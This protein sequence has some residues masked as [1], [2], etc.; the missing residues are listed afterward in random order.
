M[1]NRSGEQS[2]WY[3][4]KELSGALLDQV[5]SVNS[6]SVSAG[7]TRT[8]NSYILNGVDEA[9]VFLS[10]NLPFVPTGDYSH[11][12]VFSLPSAAGNREPAMGSNITSRLSY[13]QWIDD[14]VNG[15]NELNASA[16]SAAGDCIVVPIAIPGPSVRLGMAM[17]VNGSTDEVKMAIKTSLGEVGTNSI[18]HS[19]FQPINNN[20]LALGKHFNTFGKVEIFQYDI[21]SEV[22]SLTDLQET[23]AALMPEPAGG[24]SSF[25]KLQLLLND[26]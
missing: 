8:G 19:S 6:D 13:F 18:T 10:G 22:H 23:L 24:S 3:N 11:Y 4:F 14:G 1:S 5:V 9:V 16:N 20:Q 17:S 21:F 2:H 7:I 26:F 25:V 12:I 15:D